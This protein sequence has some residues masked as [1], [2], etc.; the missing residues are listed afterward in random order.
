MMTLATAVPLD[1]SDLV[2]SHRLH[3]IHRGLEDNLVIAAV[4]RAHAD[5]LVTNDTKIIKHALVPSLSPIDMLRL[6]QTYE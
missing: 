4:L 6:L 5:F 1:T 2:E 3:Q